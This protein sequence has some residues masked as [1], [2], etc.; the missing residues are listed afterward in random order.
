MIGVNII[1]ENSYQFIMFVGGHTSIVPMIALVFI[2]IA[3]FITAKGGYKS[4]KYNRLSYA[5]FSCWMMGSLM[6]MILLKNQYIALQIAGGMSSESANEL[7]SF[8][9]WKAVVIVG[10]LTFITGFLGAFIG[11]KMLRKHFEKAGII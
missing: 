11:K 8:I 1:N 10:I 2:G 4:S 6:Q 5:V 7:A 3:Q 9:S